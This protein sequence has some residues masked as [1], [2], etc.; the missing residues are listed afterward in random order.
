[1]DSISFEFIQFLKNSIKYLFKILNPP[2]QI[3]GSELGIERNYILCNQRISFIL[4]SLFFQIHF[5]IV[6]TL[7]MY[8]TFDQRDWCIVIFP[9]RFWPYNLQLGYLDAEDV[10]SH[11]SR[12]L[13]PIFTNTTS[14]SPES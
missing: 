6:Y 5:E 13:F 11:K 4:F 12:N 3:W 1:M 14:V 9:G 7:P 10:C 2:L 8:H